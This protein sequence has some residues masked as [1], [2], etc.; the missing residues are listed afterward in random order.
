L[1]E[2]GVCHAFNDVTLSIGNGV[3]RA[4]VIVVEIAGFVGDGWCACCCVCFNEQQYN[5][6]TGHLFTIKSGFGNTDGIRKLDV[7]PRQY[8]AWLTDS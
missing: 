5:P 8:F 3:N 2:G 4:K 6:A 7:T 1:S